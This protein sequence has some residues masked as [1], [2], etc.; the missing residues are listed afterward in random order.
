MQPLQRLK[1]SDKRRCKHPYEARKPVTKTFRIAA[2]LTAAAAL[3]ACSQAPAEPTTL[4]EGSWTLNGEASEL[5]YV[6][7]K[8]GDIAE[9]NS[10]EKL[11]GTVAK[12]GSARVEIDLA[13]VET[14]IDIRNERM[15]DIL[16]EVANNPTATVSAQLDPAAFAGLASGESTDVAMEGN[17]SLK[18]VDAPFTAAVTVTRVDDDRVLVVS[19]E[20]VLVDAGT[21]ALTEGLAQL[22]ELAALPSITP[23]TPVS[24]SLTFER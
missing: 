23:V 24:F 11:S 18:G 15:R 16:F 13:S 14:N 1:R 22:Q 12:D 10:F 6:T 8:A 5:S 7:I 20:P 19:D 9:A 4:T 17:L 21:L 3:A 2:A